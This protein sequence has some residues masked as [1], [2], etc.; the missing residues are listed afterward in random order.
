MG[1]A[2]GSIF[3]SVSCL[4]DQAL[5]PSPKNDFYGGL[6]AGSVFL[7]TQGG[8]AAVGIGAGVTMG[9]G[10]A[11]FRLADWRFKANDRNMGFGD[12]V[13]PKRLVIPDAARIA[14]VA[15]A[16]HREGRALKTLAMRDAP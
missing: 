4:A 9:V 12:G 16:K 13:L 15:E 3:T 2:I 7:T 5:G 6:A 14:E 10:A 8:G 11:L 1:A